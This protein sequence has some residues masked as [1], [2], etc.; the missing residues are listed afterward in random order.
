MAA[1]RCIAASGEDVTE[2]CPAH[3][4]YPMALAPPMAANALGRG[5]VWMSEIIDEIR[6]PIIRA[7]HEELYRNVI[8][9]KAPRA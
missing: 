7:H 8:A 1:V 2:I 5:P 4:W 9:R 3:R 6:W